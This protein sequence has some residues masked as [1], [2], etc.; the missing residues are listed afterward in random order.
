MR[1][2]NHPT[3]F[4]RRSGRAPLGVKSDWLAEQRRSKPATISH[5]SGS[6]HPLLPNATGLDYSIMAGVKSLHNNRS[7]DPRMR[8]SGPSVRLSSVSGVSNG[9]I[10]VILNG[11]GRGVTSRVRKPTGKR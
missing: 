5:Y 10:V 9:Q 4:A 1:L 3:C 6:T 11:E 7:L 8:V 2:L